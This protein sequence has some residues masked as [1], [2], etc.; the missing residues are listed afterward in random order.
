MDALEAERTEY[1]KRLAAAGAVGLDKDEFRQMVTETGYSR[2][3]SGTLSRPGRNGLTAERGA[4]YYA[5][6]I[7]MIWAGLFVAQQEYGWGGPDWLELLRTVDR[8]AGIGGLL[9][10]RRP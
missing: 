1:V 2:G 7:C 4:R 5:T 10:R 9:W 3:W 6:P 8:F